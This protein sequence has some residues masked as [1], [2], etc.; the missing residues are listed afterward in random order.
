MTHWAI[1]PKPQ[2]ISQQ[3]TPI[4]SRATA[5]VSRIATS[6]G[7]CRLQPPLQWPDQRDDEQGEG[8]RRHHA[9]RHPQR[10]EAS[11][12]RRRS[13]PRG[14][15]C[16][17]RPDLGGLS[18]STAIPPQPALTATPTG[19]RPTGSPPSAATGSRPA[20]AAASRRRARS[21]RP[22]RLSDAARLRRPRRCRLAAPRGS[23]D[24]QRQSPPKRTI[25]S[26][27]GPSAANSFPGA[28]AS[29]R[30]PDWASG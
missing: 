27:T 19:R 21:P 4:A 15:A 22:R 24:P 8:D 12:A 16:G 20:I 1:L 14:E 18:R 2:T 29:T 25:P 5:A 17:R 13:A 9:A 10:R 26:N 7:S 28:S 30:A 23:R 11:A 6:C 3:P